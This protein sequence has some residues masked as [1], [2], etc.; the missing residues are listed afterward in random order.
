MKK[1]GKFFMKVKKKKLKLKGG[2]VLETHLNNGGVTRAYFLNGKQLTKFE[3]I[4]VKK[5]AEKL[6][7]PL[8]KFAVHVGFDLSNPYTLVKLGLN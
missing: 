4:S 1:V 2:L 3:Q 8:E 5:L 7:L 6:H